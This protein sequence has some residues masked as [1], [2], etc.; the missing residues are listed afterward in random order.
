VIAHKRCQVWFGQ[1]QAIEILLTE[2]REMVH[3]F[4]FGARDQK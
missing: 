4:R 2:V 1:K 3:W